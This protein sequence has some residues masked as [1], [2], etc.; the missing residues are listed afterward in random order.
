M[1]LLYGFYVLDEVGWKTALT[2]LFSSDGDHPL[3]DYGLQVN[4]SE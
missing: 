3:V 1:S 4:R 2:F